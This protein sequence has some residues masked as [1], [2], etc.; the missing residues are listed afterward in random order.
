[1]ITDAFTVEKGN[2]VVTG[3]ERKSNWNL[4]IIYLSLLVVAIA[5]IIFN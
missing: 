2:V 1:M 3:S 5:F 4:G